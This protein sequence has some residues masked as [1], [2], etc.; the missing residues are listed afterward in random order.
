MPWVG[1]RDSSGRSW[2]LWAASPN[3]A[4]GSRAS[5]VQTPRALT[6]SGTLLG[7]L[8]KKLAEGAKKEKGAA[9]EK[10]AQQAK[11]D[12]LR[13]HNLVRDLASTMLSVP[14][15]LLLASEHASKHAS[16][17]ASEHASRSLAARLLGAAVSNVEPSQA[18]VVGAVV[19]I[20]HCCPDLVASSGRVPFRALQQLCR[21]SATADELCS[22][23]TLLYADGA[24]ANDKD[25]R[26]ALQLCVRENRVDLLASLLRLP[27]FKTT[28]EQL[29]ARIRGA[30][31]S[32]EAAP[33]D[34]SSSELELLVGG[35]S[36]PA[37]ASPAF[38]D[39]GVT[40]VAR[41]L[42]TLQ[43]RVQQGGCIGA[44]MCSLAPSS[45]PKCD[46]VKRYDTRLSQAASARKKATQSVRDKQKEMATKADQIDATTKLVAQLE[47]EM[48]EIDKTAVKEMRHKHSQ[49]QLA[50]EK[51]RAKIDQ[52][53]K[54][55]EAS[56][57]VLRHERKSVIVEALSLRHLG[58]WFARLSLA[59]RISRRENLVIRL[60][61]AV[62]SDGEVGTILCA[63]SQFASRAA[64]ATRPRVQQ[65]GSSRLT[66]ALHW[67]SKGPAEATAVA[68]RSGV[69]WRRC[70]AA[71][72]LE[73]G[74]LEAKE[75]ASKLQVFLANSG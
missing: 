55:S 53:Q 46:T 45:E 40:V 34:G 14:V 59:V 70:L 60:Q 31:F 5:R 13:L 7:T 47:E 41:Q 9:A 28:P 51:E 66:R 52:K 69:Q 29:L 27:V 30:G 10:V 57:K 12:V 8:L 24:L 22:A 71:R 11:E 37:E 21:T 61:L 20:R 32:C 72:A 36:K 17:H 19:Q 48:A 68:V 42:V 2:R 73:G 39:A 4:S 74:M 38:K 64:A 1:S 15:S 67:M 23:C 16:K 44:K 50:R 49:A 25:V 65:P 26:D 33:R 62:R 18:A 56:L 75:E 54:V 3:P 6:N 35:I 43:L 58:A 63:P